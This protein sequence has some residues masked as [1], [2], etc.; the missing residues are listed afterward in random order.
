[1]KVLILGSSGLLGNTLKI[2]LKEKKIRLYFIS[3]KK[4]SKSNLNLRNF[5]NFKKL[6][7]I[8]KKINPKYIINCIGVTHHRKTNENKIN[9]KFINSTL[10]LYLSKLCLEYKIYLVHISTDCVFSGKSGNYS[11]K[12]RKNPIGYYG[13]TKSKGEVKNRYT[14]TIRTSFIGPEVKTKNQLLNWFLAQK[15]E[16]KGFDKAFFSGLTSLELS[17]IIYTYFLKKHFFYNFILNIGGP[18]ISKYKLLLLISKIFKKKIIIKKFSKL[19]IDRSLNSKKFRKLSKY[20]MKK[21][22]K[23]LV[24]LKNFMIKNNYRLNY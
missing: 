21:W 6:E 2:F 24:E 8:I 7:Q 15:N 1:M 9:T 12:S 17:N 18:K 10:P 4:T 16:I 22:D 23:M 13:L 20:K 3:K 14:T 5:K 11:E 19:K